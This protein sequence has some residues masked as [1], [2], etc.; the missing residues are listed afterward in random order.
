MF[1]GFPY[2]VSVIFIL[3]GWVMALSLKGPLDAAI[4]VYDEL[5]TMVAFEQQNAVWTGNSGDM[6]KNY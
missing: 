5:E 2:Q 3:S 6:Y 4:E 1:K